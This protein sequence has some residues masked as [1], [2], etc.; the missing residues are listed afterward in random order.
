MKSFQASPKESGPTGTLAPFTRIVRARIVAGPVLA[1][2]LSMLLVACMGGGSPAT[3]Q[4][5][6]PTEPS[7][8]GFGTAA[9]HV[10]SLIALPGKVL[11]LATHYGIFR[12]GDDGA[13]W[14]QVAAG[15]NQLMQ[16]LMTDSLVSSPLNPQRLYVLTQIAV[17][18]PTGTLGL[19]TSSDQGRTWKLAVDQATMG[20]MFFVAP[21]ND[22]P[23]EVYVY[24]P[25]LG[26]LGLKVSLD[27]GQHFSTTG[28]L[29]FGRIFGLL[30][31]PGAPGQLLVY[32]NDGMARS[33]DGGAHWQVVKGTTGGVFGLATAGPHSP[34]YASGDAGIYASQ[35]GGKSFSLVY[36]QSTFGSLVVSPVQPD[37]LYGKTGTAIYRSA[38]GGH[39]WKTL[40]AIKGNLGNLAPDTANP[41]LLYLSLS[42]P[43]EVYLFNQESGVWSSLTPKA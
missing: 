16:G 3:V 36:S 4:T 27:A 21:G 37:V 20:N 41:A 8:N 39:S 10:H 35:D 12:S 32:G 33:S 9:N 34:I 11:V 1:V 18:H 29:P 31:I 14:T 42:Y 22:T 13:S 24:L 38:D 30:A 43:T 40:P 15:P 25:D 26:A 7:V 17:A 2:A 28:T 5:A 19:Y 6:T 23:D